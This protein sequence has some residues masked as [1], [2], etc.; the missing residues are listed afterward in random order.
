MLAS[1]VGSWSRCAPHRCT[2][3]RR[4]DAHTVFKKTKQVEY[5]P[6]PT[7]PS[8]ALIEEFLRD[9]LPYSDLIVCQPSQIQAAFDAASLPAPG[10]A[11]DG[12][13]G[14]GTVVEWSERHKTAVIVGFLRVHGL[15]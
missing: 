10:S 6:A 5:L 7:L 9:I 2:S 3:W 11:K 14:E 15:L 4:T 1:L 12:G 13:E 8:H